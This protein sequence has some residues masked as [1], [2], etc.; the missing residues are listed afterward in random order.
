[1]EMVD[2]VVRMALILATA[3]LFVIVLTAYL[4]LRNHKMLF[5]T[6]GFGI[7]FLNALIL[8]PE[9]LSQYIDMLISQNLHLFLNFVGLVFILF[10]TLKE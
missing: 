7:F 1:M 2:V 6:T 3:T 10:G 5:I 9:L 8:M 4:R